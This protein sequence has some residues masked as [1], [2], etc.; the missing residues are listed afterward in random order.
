MQRLPWIWQKYMRR[1]VGND[2]DCEYHPIIQKVHPAQY[3]TTR[4]QNGC[5]R[6]ERE[7][8]AQK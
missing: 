6:H 2:T 1:R 5:Q 3:R 7:R 8:Q 4:C